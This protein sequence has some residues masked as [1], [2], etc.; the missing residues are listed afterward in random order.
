[1]NAGEAFQ[2]K[3]SS[4]TSLNYPYS[5]NSRYGELYYERP[6]YFNEPINTG[7]NMIIGFPLYAFKEPGW[8]AGWMSV[9]GCLV[10]VRTESW[11]AADRF[12]VHEQQQSHRA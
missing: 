7:S 1:M 10:V 2:I 9:L 5:D 12:R 4:E 11:G 8:V 3:S 6:I